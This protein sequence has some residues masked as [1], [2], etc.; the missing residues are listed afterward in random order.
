VVVS[1]AI[2]TPSGREDLGVTYE[3]LDYELGFWNVEG[4]ATYAVAGGRTA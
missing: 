1:I 4:E 2:P 3:R